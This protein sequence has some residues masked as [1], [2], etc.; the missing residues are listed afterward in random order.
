VAAA[1]QAAGVPTL[2]NCTL[3]QSLTLAEARSLATLED[4]AANSGGGGQL[5]AFLVPDENSCAVMN[6]EPENACSGFYSN[7][8]S[9]SMS[10]DDRKRQ[11]AGAASSTRS[12]GP[13]NS[14]AEEILDKEPQD[15]YRCYQDDPSADFP[16]T[17]L[18]DYLDATSHS[19]AN[20][21]ASSSTNGLLWQMQVIVC[22][23][24][25]NCDYIA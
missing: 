18:F 12:E 19:F 9:T 22:H 8:L 15:V 20:G 17:R 3:L 11:L 2:T 10:L 21:T 1:L 14:V 13:S 4:G 6:Y 25:Q 24:L 23:Q 5:L 16:T 7:D